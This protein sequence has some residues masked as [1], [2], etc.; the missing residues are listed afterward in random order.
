MLDIIIC[1]YANIQHFH[2][3]SGTFEFQLFSKGWYSVFIWFHNPYIFWKMTFPYYIKWLVDAAVSATNST[4]DFL[5]NLINSI[6][7]KHCSRSSFPSGPS[8]FYLSKSPSSIRDSHNTQ[9]PFNVGKLA[10]MSSRFGLSPSF[11]QSIIGPESESYGY[12]TTTIFCSQATLLFKAA[13]QQDIPNSATSNRL[14]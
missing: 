8:H 4:V 9:Y 13:L 5:Q 10:K 1:V 6:Y 14:H 3:R 7:W 11:F 2:F 12:S